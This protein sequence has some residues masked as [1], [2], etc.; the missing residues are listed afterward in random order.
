[1]CTHAV[2]YCTPT[3]CNER[4]SCFNFFYLVQ[5]L[6]LLCRVTVYM[7]VCMNVCLSC[8]GKATRLAELALIFIPI[9]NVALSAKP[10]LHVC[11]Y[12]HK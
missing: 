4:Y 3:R 5:L 6:T 12:M 2:A 9:Y 7:N 10:P 1:M 8:E 11:M